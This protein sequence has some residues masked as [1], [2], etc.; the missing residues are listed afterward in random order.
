MGPPFP[1]SKLI[2][3]TPICIQTIESLA[4]PVISPF[5]LVGL[6]KYPKTDSS[7]LLFQSNQFPRI[8]SDPSPNNRR[9]NLLLRNISGPTAH[10]HSSTIKILLF[11][12]KIRRKLRSIMAQLW[13][14]RVWIRRTILWNSGCRRNTLV[15]HNSN[16]LLFPLAESLLVVPLTVTAKNTSP[17]PKSLWKTYS[18]P[19]CSYLITL[20]PV[21]V[22]S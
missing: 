15:T 21:L 1:I 8:V 18:T 12:K 22:C 7:I 14:T 3:R 9:A 13:I 5:T 2:L 19:D 20:S 17:L 4:L 11:Q 6:P 16:P 10:A